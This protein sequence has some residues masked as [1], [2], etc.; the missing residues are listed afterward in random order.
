V[1]LSLDSLRRDGGPNE[2]ADRDGIERAERAARAADAVV[3]VVGETGAMSGEAASRASLD[4]PGRQLELARRLVAT[5]RPVAVVLMSGRP[6]GINWLAERAPAILEAWFPGTEAGHAV[7]DV[8]FGKVN[9]GGKLPVTFPRAA[10]QE[11]L[12]YNHR[13][14]GR[15]PDPKNKY[16][17][18][19]LDLDWTPLYPFGHGLSYTQFRLTDLQVTP[20]A[21][22]ADGAVTVSATVQN[23]G[24]REGDQ[25]VQLYVRD[26]VASVTRPV[27]ELK[28]FQ[29]LTLRPGESRRVEFLLGP[30]E[31]GFYDRDMKWVVE[32]GRFEV[33]LG[34]SSVG[35]LTGSFEVR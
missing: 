31:L 21:I 4:L 30:A 10:G 35:G 6:L 17:S 29:R 23:R 5:G 26:V 19:Y 24:S 7:A 25:T 1:A 8:L 16:T 13:R 34:D 3:L 14:T 33:R 2:G 27:Q 22:P 12:S 32:P 9:P 18:K 20:A 11:P 28:G 15:P